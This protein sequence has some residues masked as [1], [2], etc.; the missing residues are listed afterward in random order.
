MA[1]TLAQTFARYAE[2]AEFRQW[3]EGRVAGYR[4]VYAHQ[5]ED[6]WKFTL[7]EWWRFVTRTIR[8][9]GAYNLP[10]SK[11]LQSGLRKSVDS[12]KAKTIRSVNLVHWSVEDWKDELGAI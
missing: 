10:L 9:N 3:N 1:E 7:E 4:F 6:V 8:N 2:D 11:H 12:G 5:D